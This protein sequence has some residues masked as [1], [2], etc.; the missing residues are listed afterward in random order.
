MQ[1]KWSKVK[2][3]L[4]SFIC[5]ALKNR[6][7]FFVV[8]YKKAD[9]GMGRAYITVD[10]KEV[11]NMCTFIAERRHYDIY[12]E[13]RFPEENYSVD[14]YDTNR[15]IDDIAHELTKKE[16]VFSQYDFFEALEFYFSVSIEK[17]L[18]SEN[19]LVKIFALIDKQTGKRTLEKLRDTIKN[20]AEIVNYFFNLRCEA[21]G[22]I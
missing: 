6:V 7:D 21:E 14:D 17:S 16:G 1:R 19:M 12:D 20:D 8:N 22:I 11:L 13:L 2:K 15:K 18:I 3:N 10:K 4:E 5:E 9:D